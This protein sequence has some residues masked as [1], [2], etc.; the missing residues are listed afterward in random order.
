MK[1][2]RTALKMK[3]SRTIFL[4]NRIGKQP[5]RYLNFSIRVAVLLLK[6]K[7]KKR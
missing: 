1:V 6:K 7:K 5:A 3:I 4:F 2:S